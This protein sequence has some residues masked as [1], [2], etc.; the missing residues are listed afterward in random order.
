MAKITP[1]EDGPLVAQ[2][3][4]VLKARGKDISPDKPAYGLC[5][6]GKSQSKPFC[7]GSHGPAGFTSD[8]GDAKIRNKAIS[9]HGQIDGQ[10]VT[11]S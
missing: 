3:I 5:R 6:C 4:P 11:V 10:D 2:G 9:Y 8:N 1:R 7:D